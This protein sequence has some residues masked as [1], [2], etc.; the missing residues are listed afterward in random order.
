MPSVLQDEP[1][2][3]APAPDEPVELGGAGSPPVGVAVWKTPGATL[4]G[5]TKVTVVVTVLDLVIV[6][7]V[8]SAGGAGVL[9][10]GVGVL[11]AGVG[12]LAAAGLE[13]L[14]PDPPAGAFPLPPPMPF[15]AAQVPV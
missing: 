10:A 5:V 9:T 15:T 13:G 3:I 11:G 8:V 4:V 1:A 6:D 2:A 14:L 7:M 12:V